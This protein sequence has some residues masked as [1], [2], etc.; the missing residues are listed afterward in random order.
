MMPP[1]II[2]SGATTIP[3]TLRLA[4]GL[5]VAQVNSTT[6]GISARGFNAGNGRDILNSTTNVMPEKVTA[7]EVGTRLRL[8]CRA[9]ANAT[10][11]SH[12][13]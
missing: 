13:G 3:E 4:P 11:G 7:Y 6:Y 9:M 10:H 12:G 8:S 5:N 2:R 1:Q